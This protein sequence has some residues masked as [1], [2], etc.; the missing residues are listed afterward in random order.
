MTHPDFRISIY[1]Y[2]PGKGIWFMKSYYTASLF[3]Y[4]QI[5]NIKPGLLF[6]VCGLHLFFRW[7][8]IEV[9]SVYSEAA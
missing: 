8:L 7:L 9:I 1:Y 6:G 4:T 2:L 3:V 5:L